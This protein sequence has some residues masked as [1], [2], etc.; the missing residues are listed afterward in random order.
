MAGKQ[1]TRLFG[2]TAAVGLCATTLTVATPSHAVVVEQAFTYNDGVAQSW[3]VPAGV[4]QVNIVA[5]G[6]GGGALLSGSTG[7]RG[8][9]VATPQT[10]SAG[11]VFT[12]RVGGG[13][14]TISTMTHAA[15]GSATSVTLPGNVPLA[16]AG[17]GG[18]AYSGTGGMGA[19]GGTNAGGS[20]SGDPLDAGGGAPG[21]GNGSAG[22]AS[23]SSTAGTAGTIDAR[24]GG[25]GAP[26]DSGWATGGGGFGG[27]SFNSWIAGSGGGDGFSGQGGT[28]AEFTRQT[29]YDGGGGAGFGG[30]GATFG[31]GGYGGG[32]GG[33]ANG[34]AGGS[35][36]RTTVVGETVY[37]G[38]PVTRSG[39]QYGRGSVRAAGVPAVAASDGLVVISYDNGVPDPGPNP[40]PGGPPGA[41]AGLKVAGTAKAKTRKSHWSAAADAAQYHLKVTQKGKKKWAKKALVSK[42][43]AA[44]QLNLKKK[45]LFNAARKKNKFTGPKATFVVH[46]RGLNGAGHGPYAVKTFKAQK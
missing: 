23:F 26:S 22:R 3:T 16:I 37:S 45:Q 39:V 7:G 5:V 9:V 10:V 11:Q 32:G 41:V 4:T 15:G 8:A 27:S 1:A 31:G 46:V 35:F 6:G 25:N 20:G 17:G 19:I 28:S 30:G 43:V 38:G 18:G 36:A 14:N 24:N 2:T 42:N 44:L 21:N 40:T 13:G 34:G 29:F 33:V 12:I